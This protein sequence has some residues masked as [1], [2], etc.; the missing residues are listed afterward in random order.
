M[1]SDENKR[2]ATGELN[3]WRTWFKVG[4]YWIFA[5]V[6]LA[7]LLVVLGVLIVLLGGI[8]FQID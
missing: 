3:D 1:S 8:D 7:G 4:R 6:F 5:A 2:A